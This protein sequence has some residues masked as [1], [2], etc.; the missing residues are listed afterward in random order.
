MQTIGEK[1]KNARIKKAISKY[2]FAKLLN[3]SVSTI[4]NWESGKTIP[5]GGSLIK[6]S[7]MLGISTNEILR[8]QEE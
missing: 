3:V 4:S 5:R 8:D 2:K 1:I 6:I 7:S